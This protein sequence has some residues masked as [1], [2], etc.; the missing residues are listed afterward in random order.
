MKPIRYFIL[1]AG[2]ILLAAALGRF[3]IGFGNAHGLSLPEPVLGIPLRYAALL[4]GLVELAAAWFCLFGKRVTLQVGCIAWLGLNY[5]VYRLAA[6]SMDAHYQTTALGGLTDP[7]HLIR[8]YAGMA[9]AFAP[10]CLLIGGGA[11]TAWLWQGNR[12]SKRRKEDEKSIKMSCP[13]CGTHIRFE[14]ERLGQQI[15][16]PQCEKFITLRREQNLKMACYFCNGHIEFPTHAINE[17]IS[18]P[19][20]KM[21]ITLKKPSIR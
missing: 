4:V 11:S 20:C 7:L 14:R 21:D 3:L 9:T 16:C 17:K 8:G 12:S 15:D 6:Q 5:V 1:I 19:H 2:A 18:C 10:I 13:E